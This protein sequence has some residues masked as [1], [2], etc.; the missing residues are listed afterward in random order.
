MWLDRAIIISQRWKEFH[1]M[2]L[3]A[4]ESSMRLALAR[5]P[6][7]VFIEKGCGW[8]VRAVAH[9][10]ERSA[11]R[12]IAKGYLPALSVREASKNLQRK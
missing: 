12:I 11:R 9:C 6:R 8:A 5:W 4:M 2:D 10:D 3:T 1:P 7:E